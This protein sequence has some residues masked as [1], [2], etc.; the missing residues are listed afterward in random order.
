[1]M[2]N[3]FADKGIS[4][5][6]PYALTENQPPMVKEDHP[7]HLQHEDSPGEEEQPDPEASYP[8]DFDKRGLLISGLI[9][10]IVVGLLILGFV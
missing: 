4:L 2:L 1:M 6:K 9:S 10:I 5:M 3:G 7:A 8:R